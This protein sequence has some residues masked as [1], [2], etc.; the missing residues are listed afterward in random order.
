MSAKP[1]NI[2]LVQMTSG[3]DVQAN[4]AYIEDAIAEA[5]GKGAAF[6]ST[7]EMTNFLPKT[8]AQAFDRAVSEDDDII[9]KA[10]IERA[11]IHSVWVHLGS[12]CILLDD[13]ALANRSFVINPRGQVTAR[14][15]KLHMFD[16][17]LGS[18][19]VYQESATYRRGTHA[20][21][22]DLC[23][24][25]WGLSICYDLR[26]AALYR[27]LASAGAHVLLVPAAFT[28]PTGEAHWETLLRARAIETGCFVLAAGQTGTH[29]SGRKTH[30][31]SIVI[32]PWGRVLGSLE[33][34]R[35][36]LYASLDLDLV[37][38]ARAKV[39]SLSHSRTFK[40]HKG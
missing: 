19:E 37:E 30:G 32:D 25:A 38:D 20:V 10:A 21:T 34:A 1:I 7:P 8:R 11:K 36:I 33:R 17:D 18:G 27:T 29:E 26:F 3:L 2:A 22:T 13:Q 14:Y 15:D 9:L 4:A 24:A 28:Q 40:L 6:I 5:A 39:P 16:V 35:S 31:H 23:G 12:L